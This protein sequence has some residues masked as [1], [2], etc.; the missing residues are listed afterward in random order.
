MYKTTRICKCCGSAFTPETG[1][2]VFCTPACREHT[3]NQTKRL[4]NAARKIQ[5]DKA[6]IQAA[7]SGKTHL[8]ITEAA[9]YLGVS[10]PTI[11][12]R[13]REGELTPL[14]VSTRTLR[15]P[16]AQLTADTNLQPRPSNGDFSILISKE[17]ALARYTI[18]ESWLYRRLRAE[19]IRPRILKGK[20][21]F[22][23][24]DLDRLF[25]PK[26][27][28]KPEDWY[29]ADDLQKSEKITRKHITAILRKKSIPSFRDGH[30]LLISKKEWDAARLLHGDI[31]KNYL[32]VDQAKKHYRIG[33]Q[34]FYD[35]IN[36]AGIT[37]TRSGNHVYYKISDLDR[38]FK[39]KSPK[40]P[41]EIRKNYMRS[42]DALKHYHLGQKR[43]SEET[44]AAGVTKI[45][46]EGN[47][48]WYKKD[49]LDKLFKKI[50]DN[51]SN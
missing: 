44:Q 27:S 7:L 48:V 34:T 17:D 28:H 9:L 35:K 3:K 22:P 45:R 33:Q 23:K 10:R 37:G 15:I 32:T 26:P 38:L 4:K 20:G 13:I 8:S 47:Y 16:I 36:A 31:E 24:K 11:Y 43:F 18:S 30:T 19:G 29:N 51:A 25:T 42:G 6:E 46:T 41:A 1:R 50:S 14:R 49:E 2:Q 5:I 39:D 40:I 12:A 21:Y